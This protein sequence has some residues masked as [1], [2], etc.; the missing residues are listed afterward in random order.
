[1][2]R[3]VVCGVDWSE[4]SIAAATVAAEITRR[5]RA[6]LV[7]AH[8]VEERPTFPY[9]SE[10]QLNRERH[11]AHEETMRLLDRLEGH[12][13]PADLERRVLYGSVAEELADLAEEED[14]ALLVVGSRG[15]GALKA[16]VF[17]SVSSALSRTSDRPVVI[18]RRDSSPPLFGASDERAKIL[19]GI[20]DSPHARRAAAA[21]A[22][23]AGALRTELVLVHAYPPAQS[24][25]AIPAG[26]AAPAL[27]HA[28]VEAEQRRRGEELL[29]S[30]AAEAAAGRPVRTRLE[31]GAPASV[32][33][34]CAR[35]EPAGLIVVGTHGRGPV[36]A[37]LLGSTS[38]ALAVDGP[39]P[40]VMISERAA[41]RATQI[42]ASTHAS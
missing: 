28:A 16:A 35:A 39:V 11:H 36:A 9:G 1:M 37:T 19:C 14:A 5:L 29:L 21:A 17:G 25:A 20:D 23:L 4:E 41:H 33:E 13:G 8:V 15:R 32:L 27:D 3:S 7:L 10:T 38:L 22:A 30:V 26:G 42:G 34:R 24:A 6:T 18:V 2:S 12:L 40:V 31:A